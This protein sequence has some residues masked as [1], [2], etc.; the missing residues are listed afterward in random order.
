MQGKIIKGIGGFYYVHDGIGKVYECRA[1]GIFRNRGIKPLVGDDVEISVLDEE[2]ATGNL[3]E[4]L[5]RK[6]RLIRPAVSNVDQAV[7]VFAIT[8]PMP[9]L[10]LLDRF[11]VMMERQEVPVSIC[12]NK[13][14]LVDA[15]EQEKLRAIYEPAGY[16]V[17]FI[18]TYE[19]SG[20]EE[21][22]RLIIGKTTVLAGPSGVGK[23]SITNFI[24]PEAQMETGGI[25]EKIRRGK[26]TTRHSELF[27]V[28]E[29][30]YMM[31]TPGFS[32]LYIEDLEPEALKGFFPEFEAYEDECRFLGCVHIGERECGVKTAVQEHK[33]GQSRYDN[34]RLMYQELKEKL[35]KKGYSFYSS[36]DTEVAIKLVDYYYKKYI[37]TY[38][39][40]KVNEI[41]E[42]GINVGEGKVESEVK[43]EKDWADTWKQYYKPVLVGERIVVKPIW[44]EYEPKGNELVVE[45]DPGM[46]FGTGTHETTRMCI[47]ALERYVNEDATVFD[48][49]CGSGI[50]TIA[51]AKLGAKL[52][53]GVDLDP[54]A[55]E[56]SKENVTYNKLNNIEILEG[57]LVEVIDGKADV[58]VANILAEIICILTDDVK[59]VL[60]DNGI[61]ITSGIIHDRVEM[62]CEKLEAT[63]FEV[64]EKNRDGEWNCI[65]AKLK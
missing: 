18:S 25:S 15:A 6:N 63:G 14:D 8:D 40:E 56:S 50:L 48:V 34:Y 30:T 35:L 33:I 47:Q 16:P 65:V 44:E 53:V 9:N 7:V 10:N 38:I 1:K 22:H 23:S 26:H 49:G 45:L 42:L 52:S 60:K 32:S 19:K 37:V 12:F 64:I 28:E 27:F 3:D 5:P 24:Q 54:V 36:T 29:G 13:I 2:K 46:A 4:I 61:F 51:A 62:V 31:D 21:F 11:L 58:V 57:N 20:L 39:E 17:H 59:R 43:Y 55:V 41:K